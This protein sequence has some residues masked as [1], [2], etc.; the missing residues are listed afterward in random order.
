MSKRAERERERDGLRRTAVRLGGSLMLA[1]A[2]L[3][4]CGSEP[5]LL[6]AP[7]GWWCPPKR[8]RFANT[9]PLS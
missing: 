4:A 1:G 2:S 9:M 6:P 3:S 5:P 8:R 7:T